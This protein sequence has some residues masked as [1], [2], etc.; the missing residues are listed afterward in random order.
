MREGV[1]HT[2]EHSDLDFTREK[3]PLYCFCAEG[4]SEE[5]RSY[6]Y[7]S[8]PPKFSICKF[9]GDGMAYKL[10]LNTFSLVNINDSMI[11]LD[12]RATL[13]CISAGDVSGR[14]GH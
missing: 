2:E 7:L 12:V 4:S 13:I 3:K 14:E 5:Q 6:L 8:L 9:G 1:P 11:H 10:E